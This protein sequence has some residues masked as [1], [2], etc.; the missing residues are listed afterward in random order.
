[1]VEVRVLDLWRE[2]GPRVLS[3][4]WEALF[5]DLEA[6]A[7]AQEDEHWRQEV[8]ERSRGERSSVSLAARVAAA[9]GAQISAVLRDGSR[10][11]GEVLESGG[12]WM[13]LGDAGRQRVV[14]LAAVVVVEDLPRRSEVLSAV[15][16]RLTVARTLR[17]LSRERARVRVRATVELTGVIAAVGQDHLDLVTEAG[18]SAAIPLGAILEVVSA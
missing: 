17:G 16:S 12:D 3:M 15:E 13:L 14:A 6:Q 18:A 8:A 7:Q 9:R 1:M 10:V 2:A 4:R 11:R 5:R